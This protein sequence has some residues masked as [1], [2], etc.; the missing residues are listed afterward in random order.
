[1]KIKNILLIAAIS[2]TSLTSCFAEEI[3]IDNPF[4]NIG[5]LY[6]KQ[7]HSK[8]SNIST[9][10]FYT[11]HQLISSNQADKVEIQVVLNKGTQQEIKLAS[12]KYDAHAK[13]RSDGQHYNETFSIGKKKG[14]ITYTTRVKYGTRG[15][16][17]HPIIKSLEIKIYS[18]S[19]EGK[20][21]TKEMR[22]IPFW[23]ELDSFPTEDGNINAKCIVTESGRSCIASHGPIRAEGNCLIA[24]Q[25]GTVCVGPSN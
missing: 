11:G 10:E 17:N 14:K 25:V 22:E 8:R 13:N 4:E 18:L 1:M 15:K 6:K 9:K 23:I 2:L 21:T 12:H 7:Y 5:V 3:K 24:E 20:E 16:G 19:I